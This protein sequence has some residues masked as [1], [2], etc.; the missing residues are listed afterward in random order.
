METFSALLALCAG[1]SPVIGEFPAQGP[2]TQ[3]FN[4][5]FDLSLNKRLSKNNREAGDLR[6]HCANYDVTVMILWGL[7]SFFS[8]NTFSRINMTTM[9]KVLATQ[10]GGYGLSKPYMNCINICIYTWIPPRVLNEWTVLYI[11]TWMHFHIFL[12]ACKT[13]ILG[14][15]IARIW[16]IFHI[17][18]RTRTVLDICDM[19]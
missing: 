17:L 10:G 6:R 19:W 7:Q 15:L 8:S 9:A 14:Y 2:V 3:S 1:N 5:F 12:N 13:Y 11:F 16:F 4:V 18:V